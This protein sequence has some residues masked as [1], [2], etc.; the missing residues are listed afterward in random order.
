MFTLRKIALGACCCGLALDGRGGTDEF[1]RLGCGL[2][3]V[4][5]KTLEGNRPL[6][7]RRA[8]SGWGSLQADA[9]SSSW[10]NGYQLEAELNYVL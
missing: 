4:C 1:Y 6:W 10:M 3:C 9:Y 7:K 8:I 5:G 2:E